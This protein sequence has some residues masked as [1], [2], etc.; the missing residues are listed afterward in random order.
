MVHQHDEL[1][2]NIFCSILSY[3][4]SCPI[5]C[6]QMDGKLRIL[7]ARHQG[8]HIIYSKF[9]QVCVCV[10]PSIITTVTKLLKDP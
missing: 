9:G 5:T 6:R 4:F 3:E 8:V 7:R 10:Q 1:D 2:E